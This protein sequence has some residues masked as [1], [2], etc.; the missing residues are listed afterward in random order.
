MVIEWLKFQVAPDA[1][2]RFVQVDD[3]IWTPVLSSY[4]G[5]LSK[6]VW[7]SPED[8]SELV[9]VIH[10][11]SFEQWQAIPSEVL[12]DTEDRFRAVMQDTYTLQAASGYQLRKMMQV[13]GC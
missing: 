11:Q 8:L 1:R 2:E 4:P 9:V 13:E 3:E 10:W 7:I 6:E 5:F 12:Q